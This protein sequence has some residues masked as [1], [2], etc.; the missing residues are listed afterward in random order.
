MTKPTAVIKINGYT[1]II[2]T[3]ST[4]KD[5]EVTFKLGWSSMRVADDRKAKSIVTLDRGRVVHVQKWGKSQYSCESS[6]MENS[7]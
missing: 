3:H 6:L 1:I 7:F 5:R 2:N 4:F